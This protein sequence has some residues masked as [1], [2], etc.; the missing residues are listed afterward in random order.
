MVYLRK[1]IGLFNLNDSDR[2]CGSFISKGDAMAIYEVDESVLDGLPFVNDR[3]DEL[4]LH[5]NKEHITSRKGS[6]D[7]FILEALIRQLYPDAVVE[8]KI[9]MGKY[10]IDIHAT[11]QN[12]E[13]YIDFLSPYD[14][15]Y[16]YGAVPQNPLEKKYAIEKKSGRTLYLWP[17]W[18]Q[19]CKGNL[20]LLFR[21][22]SRQGWGALWT[23]N[24]LFGKFPFENAADIIEE[25]SAPFNASHDGEYGYMLE[26]WN[27][28]DKKKPEHPIIQE[29]LSGKCD[30]KLLIPKGCRDASAW[31]PGALK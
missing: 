9:R 30:R 13:F 1:G 28:E 20:Q 12:M 23:S 2:F 7:T 14:F 5:K 25:L 21:E 19:R 26:E 31:L 11:T 8:Q 4:D 6:L 3:I 15:D 10:T 29:I 27:D 16:S 22:Q 24:H 18:I 17:Y